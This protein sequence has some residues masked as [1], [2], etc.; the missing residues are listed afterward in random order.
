[1]QTTTLTDGTVVGFRDDVRAEFEAGRIVLTSPAGVV[2]MRQVGDGLTAALRRLADGPVDPADLLSGLTGREAA[3][4]RGFLDR[5]PHLLARGVVAAEQEMLRLERT[6]PGAEY[7]PVTVAPAARVRLSRFAFCRSREGALVLESPL[8]RHRVLLVHP[9]A[10]RLVAELGAP[11][12]P[13]DLAGDDLDV[14]AVG[15]LL[16]HLVGAGLVD[17]GDSAGG[18]ESE[19]DPTLRQWSFH[20]LLF[21]SRTRPGRY[22]DPIGGIYPHRGEI[23]PLP[24]VKEPPVGRTVELYRPDLDEVLAR[25]PAFTVALEGRRSIRSYGE[26]PLTLRQLGEFLYRVGRVRVLRG[27]EGDP[28]GN[29]IVGRPYPTGGSAYEI[30]LYLTVRRCAGLDAGIWF[31]DSVA[32]RLVL[33]NDEP[34]DQAA[35]LD[36]AAGATGG[37]ADGDVLITLTS[38]FQRLS[39]KYAGI[40]YGMTLRHCG[41]V[42]QTMYLVA[43]AMGLAPCGLGIGDADLAAR[44][45]RLDWLRETSV[46]DF[47]LGSRPEGE[48][49]TWRTEDGWQLLNGAEWALRAGAELGRE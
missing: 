24:A 12:T 48:L 3:Q 13:M 22:D 34:A 41:V 11:R 37:E 8:A 28:T 17:A 35:M 30:E 21:H 19:T 14:A 23:P 38:R 46:G 2:A 4:L 47:L 18:F 1:M 10:R 32:H 9:A 42:Y 44:V 16:G 15:T 43:T 29:E 40:A 27:A 7:A 39:W 31:Y 36:V 25:D 6:A 20:D 26:E 33:V 45:L 49:G 5:A